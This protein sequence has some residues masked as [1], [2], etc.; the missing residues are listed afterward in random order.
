MEEILDVFNRNGKVI[1]KASREEVHQKGLWH[2][3]V[4]GYI[5]N[6]KLQV[7]LQRRSKNKQY[8]N[9]WDASVAGHLCAGEKIED[10]LVRESKEEIG[11]DI[12]KNMLQHILSDKYKR[13]VNKQKDFQI[14][15]FFLTRQKIDIEKLVIDE[16][17]VAQLKWLSLEK[18]I[19]KLKNKD[20]DYLIHSK[21]EIKILNTYLLFEKYK[22]LLKNA[23]K[24]I[25]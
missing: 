24:I 15:E 2:K 21:N 23:N 22:K 4:V 20:K 5:I 18:Y 7:L 11:L 1:G 8:P 13:K 16:N 14:V 3:V 12:N 19:E 10:A 6:D 17:E 9:V 25:K